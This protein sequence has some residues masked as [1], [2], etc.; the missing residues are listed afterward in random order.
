[1]PNLL[2]QI[3]N[4]FNCSFTIYLFS[5]QQGTEGATVTGSIA[6]NA[7]EKTGHTAF[8]SIATATT[9]S[10]RAP[11]AGRSRIE[12]IRDSSSPMSTSPPT[13]PRSRGPSPSLPSQ[14]ETANTVSMEGMLETRHRGRPS[15]N[16]SEV[17]RRKENVPV[18]GALANYV[19]GAEVIIQPTDSVLGKYPHLVGARGIIREAPVH[20]STWFKVDEMFICLFTECPYVPSLAITTCIYIY[21]FIFI[22]DDPIIYETHA[23]NRKFQPNHSPIGRAISKCKP[24]ICS[25]SFHSLFSKTKKVYFPEHAS[26][27]T[28]RPSALRL[29][30]QN[31]HTKSR[32]HAAT[33]AAIPAPDYSFLSGKRRKRERERERAQSF[34]SDQTAIG[35]PGGSDATLG[36]DRG[37]HR[38]SSSSP[39][40]Q[41]SDG[42]GRIF[43]DSGISSKRA[44]SPPSASASASA[45]GVRLLSSG[46]ADTWVGLT[47]QARAGRGAGVPL[48]VFIFTLSHVYFLLY[49]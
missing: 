9:T 17:N 42:D 18:A 29:P 45:R 22:Y 13:I 37:S 7:N 36:P 41:R 21:I 6:G 34:D 19:A 15:L 25:L 20:P 38:S 49:I 39:A 28:L 8:S 40:S 35:S 43:H 2:F 26:V 33:A 48:Q 44:A 32:A 46:D 30:G 11:R 27:I 31:Q 3:Y 5:D 12:S 16:E 4:P 1:M 10:T 47:V 23:H 14:S 24:S